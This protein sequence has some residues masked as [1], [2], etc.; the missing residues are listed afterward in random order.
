MFSWADN[1]FNRWCAIGTNQKLYIANGGSIYD[2]TPTGFTTGRADAFPGVGFGF[3][4][5]GSGAFGV[6]PTI[7]DILLPATWSFDNWGEWLVGVADCD[8]KI[9]QWKPAGGVGTPAAVITPASGDTVP[10]GNIGVIASAER[11]LMALGAGGDPRNIAWCDQGDNTVWTAAIA[12]TAGNIRLQTAGRIRT[13]K[14]VRGQVVIWTDVDLHVLNYLG[15][16]LIY[17]TERVGG[18]AGIASSQAVSLFESGAVWMSNEG[19][20]I[21]DGAM[22]DLKCDVQDYVFS[23]FNEQQKSKVYAGHNGSFGEVW[24][25]YPSASSNENDSYVIWNYRENHWSIGKLAR[26]CW[27]DSGVFPNPMAVS[28]DGK[29]YEHETGWTSDGSP[30]VSSRYMTASGVQ[31]GN[32]DRLMSVNQVL[33]DE[34]T[35]GQVTLQFGTQMTPEGTAY[36]YGPY[37]LQ[38]YTDVRFTGRQASVQIAGAADADWRVGTI[39][40]DAVQSGRR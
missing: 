15:P 39:R 8:G 31:I 13:A 26:T 23:D 1:S 30:L 12:N 24:W 22:H 6:A 4:P 2:I 9:Y 28:P 25:F 16:P 38:P 10:T 5:F 11:Y 36:N 7:T 34:R 14:R 29:L 32:G 21:Y 17:G 37:M 3:G 18:F 40:L 35:Q 19:F 33:P 20:F 27:T